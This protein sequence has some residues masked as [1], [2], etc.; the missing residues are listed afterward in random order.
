EAGITS[1][2]IRNG[3]VLSQE[4]FMN[5][6]EEERNDLMKNSSAVQEKLNEA[7][8][9]YRELEKNIKEKIKALETETA[10]EVVNLSFAGFIEKHQEYPK[11]LSH[12]KELQENLVENI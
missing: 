8:R 3:E 5:M 11:V 2:P 6:S 9:Q 10:T 4:D 7:F 1:I 12:V